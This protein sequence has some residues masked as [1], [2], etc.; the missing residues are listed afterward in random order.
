MLL[1][2]ATVTGLR[3]VALLA[4]VGSLAP[5]P[6]PSRLAIAELAAFTRLADGPRIA[7]PSSIDSTGRTDAS[8]KLR[9]FIARVPDRSTIVFEKGGTYRLDNAIRIENRR[10]LTFD[11]EGAILRIAGCSIDDSAFVIDRLASNITVREF[12]IVGDNANGGT[13]DA[14]V[15]NCEGQMG[16]AV[17]SGSS[18]EI[19]NVNIQRTRGDCVYVSEGGPDRI[20]SRHVWFHDSV[21]KLNGRMGVAVVG[22]SHVMVER[23]HFYKIALIVLDIEPNRVTGGGT[24]VTFRNNT[25]AEYGVSPRYTSWFVAAH[26][27][28]GSTVHD[29]TVT[30]NRVMGGAPRNPNTTVTDAGLRTTIRVQRRQRVVFANNST[31]VKGAGPALYFSHVDGLTVTDNVQPLTKGSLT[32]LV[33]VTA[34]TLD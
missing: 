4:I 12:I 34:V 2:G 30:G 27:E 20:W 28:P 3:T 6:V 5:A 9:A 32:R 23:V 29:L 33:D 11:G 15:S 10:R 14:Y 18:V 17:Y 25:V 26:G 13:T 22:G 24:Y 31:T 8:A 7:V 19:A 21:C 16:V 1:K